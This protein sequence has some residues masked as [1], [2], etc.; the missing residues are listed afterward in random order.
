MSVADIAPEDGPLSAY[1]AAPGHGGLLFF[2]H[3]DCFIKEGQP[4]ALSVALTPQHK[5]FATGRQ[6]IF[7]KEAR[8][9]LDPLGKKL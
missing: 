6:G 8:K 5:I 9:K 1:L 7:P 4:E 2:L 3:I